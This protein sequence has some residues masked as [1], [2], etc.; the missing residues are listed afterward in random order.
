MI[1]DYEEI[2]L[3]I[4]RPI[5]PVFLKSETIFIFYRAL[6]DSGADHC[7]FS[8]DVA[9]L[10]G[11]KL[12]T[13]DTVGFRGVHG[14]EIIGYRSKL[15]IRINEVMYSTDVI[16]AQISD[17]GHAILG[18]KGFFDHFDVTLSYKPQIIELKPVT[19]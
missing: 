15:T 16:F 14:D 9:D 2:S 17:F 8:V 4:K 6:I 3:Q 7:I 13:K 1:F 10:L 19:N 18:Q 11:I 5:I 12:A